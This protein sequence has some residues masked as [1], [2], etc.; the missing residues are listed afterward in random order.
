MR[1]PAEPPLATTLLLGLLSLS[2]GQCSL[3]EER[4]ASPTEL[5]GRREAAPQDEPRASRPVALPD[6]RH[7]H[8]LE[9]LEDGTLLVMG[10]FS[11]RRE[12]EHRGAREVWALG[13]GRAEWKRRADLPYEHTFA[14][15]V[16]K[17]GIVYLLG[18]GVLRYVA[19]EDRWVELVPR[20]NLPATHFGAALYRGAACVVGGV[21]DR[22]RGLLRVDLTTGEITKGAAPP[23]YRRGDHFHLVATLGEELHVIGGFLDSGLS[24]QHLSWNGTRWR[25]RRDAPAALWA[26][27]AAHTHSSARFYCFSEAGGFSYDAK[28][29]DWQRLAGLPEEH[30][31]G[32]LAMPTSW[33]QGGRIY[34]LGGQPASKAEPLLL[35]FDPRSQ[36]WVLLAGT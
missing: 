4:T 3:S 8:S 19:E 2:L 34:V 29:D 27:F 15:S 33:L 21:G 25:E 9:R 17:D 14:G 32:Y 22:A 18:D 12:A 31:G 10:G 28:S 11:R 24:K 7:G 26:K 5:Q 36:S 13:P 30:V 20:G 35:A 16:Q 6:Q 1:R 23:G